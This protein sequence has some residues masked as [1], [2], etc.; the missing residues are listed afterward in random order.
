M[1]T[2]MEQGSSMGF[3]WCRNRSRK[4]SRRSQTPGK[5]KGLACQASPLQRHMAKANRSYKHKGYATWFE[6]T[7]MTAA[8]GGKKG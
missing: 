7:K 4:K 8:G 5:S 3:D 2:I 6:K 1:A